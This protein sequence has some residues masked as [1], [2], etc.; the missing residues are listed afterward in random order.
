MIGNDELERVCNKMVVTYVRYVRY[1]QNVLGGN[2]KNY[3]T[4]QSE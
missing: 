1:Y 3:E 4:H 2:E